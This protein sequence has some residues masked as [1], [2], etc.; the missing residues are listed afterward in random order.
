MPS[1]IREAARHAAYLYGE[2]ANARLLTKGVDGRVKPGQP[3]MTEND[4]F[5]QL[6]QSLKMRAAFSVRL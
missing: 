4:S 1:I 6:R 2:G 5:F 3:A